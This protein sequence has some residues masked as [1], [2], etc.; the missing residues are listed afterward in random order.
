MFLFR[1]AA[2]HHGSVTTTFLDVERFVLEDGTEIKYP[3]NVVPR[4]VDYNGDGRMDLLAA[5]Q[6]RV[7]LHIQ[8]VTTTVE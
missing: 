7:Y 4:L 5:A 3:N 1:P 2:D 8:Q 6:G